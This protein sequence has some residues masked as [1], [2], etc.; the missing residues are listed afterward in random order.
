MS[1]DQYTISV[2]Q[3]GLR[4]IFT[5]A[6][7]LG[8]IASSTSLAVSDVIHQANVEIDEKGGSGSAATVVQFLRMR[9]P[10]MSFVA[11]QP[12]LFFIV[13]QKTNIPLFAG[14]LSNPQPY[15]LS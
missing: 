11:D 7:D 9:T 6:S 3:L 13:D 8:G 1:T 15:N 4:D 10:T 12:F 5:P 2:K 14:K